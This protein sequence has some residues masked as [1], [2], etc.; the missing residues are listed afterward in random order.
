MTRTTMRWSMVVMISGAL[1]LA[2]C[3]GTMSGDGMMKKDDSMMMKKDGMAG[4]KEM[5]KD[6]K[7]T[8]EKK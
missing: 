8:M 5:M 4:D 1:A 7:G 3:S 2:G 6:D